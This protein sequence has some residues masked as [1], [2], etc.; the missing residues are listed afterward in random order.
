[1]YIYTYICVYRI[2]ADLHIH[3]FNHCCL[4][5]IVVVVIVIITITITIIIS[6]IL[7]IIIS[8]VIMITVTPIIVII[9]TIPLIQQLMR[10]WQKLQ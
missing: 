7:S 2:H 6:I 3:V 4:C 10:F 9:N 5:H 1:M 8:I